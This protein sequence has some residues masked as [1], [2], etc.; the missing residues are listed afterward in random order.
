MLCLQTICPICNILSRR[1]T[2]AVGNRGTIQSI[3][4]CTIIPSPLSLRLAQ[5]SPYW[6][7]EPSYIPTFSYIVKY[8]KL[9]YLD[10]TIRYF[11]ICWGLLR[12]RCSTSVPMAPALGADSRLGR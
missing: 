12:Q 1:L 11:P 10:P 2:G 5:L 3:G 6:G 4:I 8:L 9:C 7:Y